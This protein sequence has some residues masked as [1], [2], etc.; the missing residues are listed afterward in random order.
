MNNG[1][2]DITYKKGSLKEIVPIYDDVNII[3]GAKGTGKSESLNKIKD[4]FKRKNI[5]FKN[6]QC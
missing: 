6:N 1:I 2:I 4:F 5:D 3:F